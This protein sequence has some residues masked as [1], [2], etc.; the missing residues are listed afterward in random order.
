MRSDAEPFFERW[1]DP[2]FQP[3]GL[4]RTNGVVT[5]EP[6]W[7]LN[8]QSAGLGAWP[9]KKRPVR[10]WQKA[11]NS[12]VEYPI[13]NVKSVDWDKSVDSD[14]ATCTI[15]LTNQWM[16][17]N[18]E[19]ALANELGVPGYFTFDHGVSSEA[20]SRWNHETNEW[21]G[22]LVPGA[23]IRTY[24]GHGGHDE[25]L[26]DAIAAKNLM[27]TGVWQVDDVTINARS[28]LI[29]L[30]CRDMMSLLIDQIIYPPLVPPGLYPLRYQRW[31]D[32]T[33]ATNYTPKHPSPPVF[34]VGAS[35]PVTYEWSSTD[36]WYGFNHLLHGH[37]GSD[38]LDGNHSTYWLSVGNSGPDK[39][40]ATDFIQFGAAG[41]AVGGIEV[42]CWAGGYQMFVSVMEG[43][44]WLGDQ[45]IPYDPSSLYG[46][47]PTVVNT[48]AN[49]PYIMQVGCPSDTP[50][51]VQFPRVINAERIR[52]TFRH[53]FNSGIG[54][55][56]YRAGVREFRALAS[57]QTSAG[58]SRFFGWHALESLPTGDGYWTMSF[59]GKVQ[60]FG[61]C[62]HYG[63][64]YGK[65]N[66]SWVGIAATS[67]G[68][69][70]WLLAAEGR[71][72]A[73]GD[74][75]HL[76]EHLRD[77]PVDY[78]ASSIARTHTG[79]GYWVGYYGGAI[80]NFGD[81]PAYAAVPMGVTPAFGTWPGAIAHLSPHPSSYGLWIL[82]HDGTIH[83]RGAATNLGIGGVASERLMS[84][85][86]MPDGDGYLIVRDDGEVR[87]VGSAVGA[88][89]VSGH[90]GAYMS[91]PD[92]YAGGGL[93]NSADAIVT[94]FDGSGYWVLSRNGEIYSRGNA[95][96]WGSP[97]EGA[98]TTRRP[99]NYLDYSD[100][101][102]DLL[103]WSGW[104][105]KEEIAATGKPE[106]YG[107]IETT[108]IY[109]P[110][111]LPADMFDKRHPIDPI[112]QLREI[113]GYLCWVDDEGAFRFE[114][115]NW[116]AAGNFY[117]DG[118]HTDFIPEIDERIQ[119]TDY[120][121]RFT[122]S[123]DRSKIIITTDEP[124]A[125]FED[126]VATEY[127]PS[128]SLLRGQIIPAMIKVPTNV[129]KAEQEIMAELVALHMW[130]ARRQGNVTIQPANPAIQINDQVR[131]FERVTSETYIHYVRGV[132]SQHDF[133]TGV[134]TMTLT[135]N[136][137]GSEDGQWAIT[138]ENIPLPVGEERSDTSERFVLSDKVLAFIQQ[139]AKSRP[140]DDIQ[141]SLTEDVDI[142]PAADG[143][144]TTS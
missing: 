131:I 114:T 75:V 55:W 63:D 54:P 39:P 106:V 86:A 72:A 113:V 110:D 18:F 79:D 81:A 10:W 108:G 119:L 43:G 56:L 50:F 69:G 92:A 52:V 104:F 123:K 83:V 24:E 102:K 82:T 71:V 25:T 16:R 111:P 133:E 101:V 37:R 118:T 95:N 65:S 11:D 140:P 12:Q 35:V 3:I 134:W 2:D 53:L 115:P 49:I 7:Y 117:D 45:I 33:E 80:Y 6:T 138:A 23:L 28:R 22:R 62:V 137:L 8:T 17:T 77:L 143:S 44:R 13:P 26:D 66:E 97:K 89:V 98:A 21:R 57:V 29:E 4:N 128:N 112:K 42:D 139:L 9:V 40:F 64:E 27:L 122:R 32:T 90:T 30:K 76:G 61:E 126:T 109:S 68:L 87:P 127:T 38:A 130:F 129:T 51:T 88:P 132:S 60:A 96:R 70:Y 142:P 144:A 116:W 121:A 1:S 105:L 136:W 85:D 59:E 78:A 31:I 100:I 34:G 73:F 93:L 41:Q 19:A 48:G 46:T 58:N 107:N 14:A 5:C 120:G 15:T 47:Q 20:Q 84:I 36:A 91:T 94:N 67:T 124:T 125:G 135:T 103:L 99:G 74:A 141:V